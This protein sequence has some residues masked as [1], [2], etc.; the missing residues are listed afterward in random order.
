M[1]FG[2]QSVSKGWKSDC[3][4]VQFFLRGF[5]GSLSVGFVMYERGEGE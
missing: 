5:K 4:G 3:V 2:V 1:M